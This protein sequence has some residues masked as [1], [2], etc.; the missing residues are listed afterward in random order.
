MTVYSL[1]SAIIDLVLSVPYIPNAGGDVLGEDFRETPGGGIY[2][3]LASRRCGVPSTYLGR[4]GSGPRGSLIQNL[5]AKEGISS[6]LPATNERDTGFC[7][8]MVEP[9]SER[10]FITHAG[11]EAEITTGLY[12]ELKYAA[13][14]YLIVSGYDLAYSTS[15]VAIVEHLQSMAS[16]TLAFDP[17]PL[18]GEIPIALLEQVLV[19]TQILSLN[20]REFQ[21]LGGD[22]TALIK[23][24]AHDAIIVLRD[25]AKGST[26]IDGAMIT[27][28]DAPRVD[29]IDSTGA[30]D[31]HLGT[32]LAMRA[33]NLDWLTSLYVANVAAA[34]SVT[35]FGPEK[36]PTFDEIRMSPLFQSDKYS[37]LEG[38]D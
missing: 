14:D 37:A 15:Q 33:R 34:I 23:R 36:V 28:L 25:G 3:L 13:D 8:T 27:H 17:G 16:G 5:F 1:E 24:L 11:I 32:L 19:R 22:A 9:N 21:L 2:P 6:F 12:K 31:I 29:S 26:L 38:V 7:I 30:G 4:C 18:V 35:K 20:E 10:T